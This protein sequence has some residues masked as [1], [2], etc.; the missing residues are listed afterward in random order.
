MQPS[1][2]STRSRAIAVLAIITLL[3]ILSLIE[4]FKVLASAS[5]TGRAEDSHQLD[6]RN[7]ESQLSPFSGPPDDIDDHMEEVSVGDNL[8][9]EA[10]ISQDNTPED[11]DGDDDGDDGKLGIPKLPLPIPL[12]IPISTP[13][14]VIASIL[15]GQGSLSAPIPGNPIVPGV[16]TP[17]DGSGGGV[18]GS[19]LSILAGSPSTPPT[20]GSAGGSSGP[21]GGLLSALSQAAPSPDI[22]PSPTAPTGSVSGS[23]PLAGL[24]VLGGVASALG[25]VLGGSDATNNGGDGLLGQLSAN[26]LDPLSSIAADP[27]AIL[28][29]PTAAINNLQSQV[30]AVLDGMPS[31]VAA[32]LQLASNVGGDVADALNATTNV[33]E[34]APDVAGG[35]ADQVGSLLNAGPALAT[36]LPAAAMAAVD[37]VGSILSGIPGIGSTVSGL[38]DGMKD[39]LSNAAASAAPQVSAMAAVVGSQVAGV[40]PTGLQPLVA[41][42]VA[43]QQTAAPV[44]EALEGQEP[45]QA[46]QERAPMALGRDH[47]LA[48][49][50]PVPTAWMVGFAHPLRL[51]QRRFLAVT[52][53]LA[54]TVKATAAPAAPAHEHS[55]PLTQAV[56]PTNPPTTNGFQSV[57]CYQDNS[58]RSLRDAQLLSVAGGMTNEQCTGFCQAQGFPIA[59]TEDGTQCFCGTLLLDSVG[60]DESQCNSRCSGDATNSTTCGGPWALSIWTIDGSIQQAKSQDSASPFTSVTTPG[61]QNTLAIKSR[62][63]V[64]TA[65]YGRPSPGLATSTGAAALVSAN[66]SNLESAILAAVAAEA[67][68][69]APIEPASARGLIESVSMILNMG[70]SSIASDLSRAVPAGNTDFITGSPNIP[71]PTIGTSGTSFPVTAAASMPT[72]PLTESDPISSRTAASLDGD[73]SDSVKAGAAD[74]DGSYAFPRLPGAPRGRALFRRAGQN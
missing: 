43:S 65:L 17:T 15:G 29:D 16:P 72:T 36:G 63:D 54:I 11:D 66:T 34:D 40:L 59:G 69:L 24:N 52:A 68:G 22:T 57:G 50:T 26:I 61:L 44:S 4:S 62:L 56:T 51:L 8:P 23:G 64:A 7:W 35:V 31:A 60:L 30:S 13:L 53:G 28:A 55:T 42:A 21:L 47:A 3:C 67:S 37:T 71:L 48:R 2:L 1:T 12:S 32:G 45:H 38:L 9:T 49:A 70:M 73:G 5:I 19:V 25:G 41:A 39:D 74:D 14:S 6:K 20:P 10:K 33:L 58:D 18:F 27:A 46:P